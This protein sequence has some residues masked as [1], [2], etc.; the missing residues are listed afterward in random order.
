MSGAPPLSRQDLVSSV[1]AVLIRASEAAAREID[2]AASV[3]STI[4]QT[5]LRADTVRGD[6]ELLCRGGLEHGFATVCVNPVWVEL[7]ASLLKGSGVQVGTVAGFPLGADPPRMKAAEAEAG[8]GAGA[9]EI[10]MVMNVGA[11]K[12]GDHD[13]VLEDVQ[14]V[15]DVCLD[16]GGLLKVILETTLLT[17]R[18]KV[19]GSLLCLEA[20]ADFVKTSTGF[21]GGGATEKDVAILRAAVGEEMGVK[22]SGGIRTRAQVVT[23]LRAGATRIGTSTGVEI[24]T[25]AK[26]KEGS[27]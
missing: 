8:L 11:L 23:M 1:D 5:L 4:D 15:V 25:G 16:R 18:E 2:P 27:F 13:R 20:G 19:L 26:A 12:E 21:A 7:A 3:A 17:D 24:V 22:A 14:A 10:D 9:S 6:V